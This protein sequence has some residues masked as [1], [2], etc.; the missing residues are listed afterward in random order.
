ME[1]ELEILRDNEKAAN[2]S[3]LYFLHEEDTFD[4]K[5]FREYL[6]CLMGIANQSVGKSLDRELS[7]MIMNT[8]GFTLKSF[9]YHQMPTDSYEIQNYPEEKITMYIEDLSYIVNAYIGGYK[10]NPNNLEID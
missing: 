1:K 5:A 7:R 8:Y 9:I 3:F 4:E 6:R 2:R 10:V